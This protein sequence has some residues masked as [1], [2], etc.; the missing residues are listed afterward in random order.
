MSKFSLISVICFVGSFV[1]FGFQA[2]SKLMGTKGE[3]KSMDMIDL[4]GQKYFD[5][6]DGIS[7]FGLEEGLRFIV[8][9]PLF[10]L[11]LCLG[12]LFF[13]MNKIF[14]K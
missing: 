3:W 5:W 2:I 7:L 8:T 9:T 13:I 14:N 12:V 4:F 6:L 11:L 1:L 10:V